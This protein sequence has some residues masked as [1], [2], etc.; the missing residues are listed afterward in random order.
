MDKEWKKQLDAF[1][2]KLKEPGRNLDN[3]E[4]ATVGGGAVEL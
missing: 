1:C 3:A 4:V 2:V